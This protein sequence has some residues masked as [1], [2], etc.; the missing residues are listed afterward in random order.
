MKKNASSGFTLVEVL[1][2]AAIIALLAAIAIPNLLAARR[3][4]NEAAAKS[5]LRS[6]STAAETYSVAHASNYPGSISELE[7]FITSAGDY[8]ADGNGA[9]KAVQGYYYS[10]I[11]TSG[12]YILVAS[13]VIPGNTGNI[14]YTAITGGALTPL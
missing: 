5:S 6:I 4:A 12:G 9:V 13:P 2:V 3:T 11:L 7:T 8:C 1:L 14:T 10:C